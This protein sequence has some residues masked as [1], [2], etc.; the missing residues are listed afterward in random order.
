MPITHGYVE[1]NIPMIAVNIGRMTLVIAP[2][3]ASLKQNG[4]RVT[5]WA[6]PDESDPICFL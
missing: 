1:L 5:G 6:G 4:D 2:G 3:K